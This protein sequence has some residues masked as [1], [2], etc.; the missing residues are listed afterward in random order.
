MFF[1]LFHLESTIEGV[2]LH[3]YIG[4]R[5]RRAQDAQS[6]GDKKEQ[7]GDVEDGKV[8]ACRSA[9][10]RKRGKRVRVEAEDTIPL[11]W[12]LC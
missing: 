5:A 12:E 8:Q 10:K 6:I 2:H 3:T 11:S 7:D 4:G 1:S 9:S